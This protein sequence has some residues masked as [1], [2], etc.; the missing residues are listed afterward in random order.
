MKAVL[1]PL[2]RVVHLAHYPIHIAV[3]KLHVEEVAVIIKSKKTAKIT[4]GVVIMLVG[5][6]M[7]THPVV[8]I[9]HVIWDALA[10]GLHG[11]GALPLIKI[12]CKHLNL[13]EIE[14]KI[15]KAE[16]ESHHS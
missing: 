2:A 4:V 16:R 10:Y 9:P 7:A 11:Y 13:E 12:A 6:T 5:S 1:K 15:E 14:E 3:E 8:F